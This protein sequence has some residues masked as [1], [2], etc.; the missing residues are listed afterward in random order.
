MVGSATIR[1]CYR[2]TQIYIKCNLTSGKSMCTP[3]S[4]IMANWHKLSEFK[5]SIF[6]TR[7]MVYS[8]FEIVGTFSLQSC[9]Y[10]EYKME[11]ITDHYRQ[12]SSKPQRHQATI[13]CSKR[14]VRLSQIIWNDIYPADQCHIELQHSS[15]LEEVLQDTRQLSYNLLYRSLW[16]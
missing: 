2:N 15:M 16:L 10:Q 6:D 3:V 11:V 13:V 7:W 1:W 9:V 4:L 14:Q 12:C 5:Q 8:I